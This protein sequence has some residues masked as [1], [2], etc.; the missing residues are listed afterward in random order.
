MFSKLRLITTT[1]AGLLLAALA[2]NAQAATLKVGY[3]D[4]PGWV[5]WQVAIDKGWLKEAGL[6]MQF[7]WFDYS[8][9][10]DA[11]SANK[12]DAVLAT[13]GDALV[14]GSGGAKG[15]MILATD[16]SNGNDMIIGKPGVKSIKALKG[17]KVG[18]EVG[19]VEN[20][21]LL[22][23]LRQNGMT[24][25]DVSLVNTKTNDTPQ[26]L[27]SGQVD[28][29]GVWQPN[30][31]TALQQVP[32][33]RPLFTS[34]KAPGLIYDVLLVN[35]A[36]LAA[37]K[38]DWKKMMAIWDR[39]VHYINDPKTQ[40]DA[41]KIMSARDGLTPATYKPLLVGTHLIDHAENK[42]VYKKHDGLTSLY[43]ST[44]NADAF[45]V[46]YAVYKAKQDVDSYI[47]PSIVMG[48]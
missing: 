16:Y 4:W 15:S 12:I 39:V 33:S 1:C 28:A 43:G 47:D 11:Y 31:G 18:I 7:V 45:N 25:T 48:H 3:S 34:A 38:T 13:N 42:K 20:L 24:D 40:P 17:K 5:A 30:A 36:S 27:A 41:L 2:T 26:V 35:P 8:A 19:L 9:S 32:G 37:H 6:D 10:L 29:I 46:K 44:A 22:E 23:A 14:V 21:L